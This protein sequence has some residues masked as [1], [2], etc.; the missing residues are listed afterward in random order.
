AVEQRQS[1]HD[2]RQDQDRRDEHP[3]R[4]A[5]VESRDFLHGFGDRY[6][7]A[8]FGHPVGDRLGRFLGPCSGRGEHRR[9]ER[10]GAA[11]RF[12]DHSV[13]PHV[14]GAAQRALSPVSPVRMRVVDARSSTK[15]FPSPMLSVLAVCWMVS[16]T[17][18]ASPSL[19]AISSFT[20]GS[21]LVE[22]SAPRKISVW[23]FCRPKPLTSE[24]VIP[25]TPIA[26]SAS[27]TSSSLNG[28]MMAMM[29]F[30][31]D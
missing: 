26:P 28:L 3:G 14:Q 4:V 10:A 8:D 7:S 31:T 21:M 19:A 17:C 22:Y 6:D 25:A 9:A 5:G 11:K 24:T 13:T 23:P 1:R 27:R 15:I 2:H 29:N 18:W 20:F 30:I 12:A 16:M